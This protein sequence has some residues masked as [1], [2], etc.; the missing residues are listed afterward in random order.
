MFISEHLKI[1]VWLFKKLLQ[2]KAH[3]EAM[4]WLL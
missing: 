4:S 3:S 1:L 2:L